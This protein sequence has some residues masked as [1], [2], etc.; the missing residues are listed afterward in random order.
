M[1]PALLYLTP[2]ALVGLPALWRGHPKLS[3]WASGVG[4]LLGLIVSVGAMGLPRY[5]SFWLGNMGAGDGFGLIGLFIFGAG[6][7][8]VAL[9]L[10][11]STATVAAYRGKTKFKEVS[12]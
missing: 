10:F 8:G 3:L 6:A 5:S 4:F 11:L 1:I 2:L 7:A 9:V 12:E